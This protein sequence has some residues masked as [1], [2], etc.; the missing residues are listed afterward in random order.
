MAIDFDMFPL[1]DPL[2]ERG[3]T[4]MA[5]NWMA[6][7]STFYM[8]LISYLTQNGILLPVLTTK[9][10]DAIQDPQEGQMIYNRNATPGPPRS[11]AI[12]VWQVKAGTGAWRT[13]TTTP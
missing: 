11:A 10:R 9:E 1:Y 8:N 2:V 4:F 13:F 7:M 3:S 6:F 5:P 12:Q